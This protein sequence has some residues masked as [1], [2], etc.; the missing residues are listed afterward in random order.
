MKG[1]AKHPILLPL[2]VK[3]ERGPFWV[4]GLGKEDVDDDTEALN[5]PSNVSNVTEGELPNDT[6]QSTDNNTTEPPAV[7]FPVG[8]T[9]KQC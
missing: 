9:I 2:K 8:E 4:T 5:L 7:S 6:A 3:E 1:M